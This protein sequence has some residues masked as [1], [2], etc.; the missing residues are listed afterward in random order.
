MWMHVLWRWPTLPAGLADN[1]LQELTGAHMQMVVL[2]STGLQ[3]PKADGKA[4]AACRLVC[5]AEL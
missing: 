4:P 3:D 2:H 5:V 1:Q